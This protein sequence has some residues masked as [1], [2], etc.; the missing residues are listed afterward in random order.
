MKLRQAWRGDEVT[1]TKRDSFV[2]YLEDF[3]PPYVTWA[4]EKQR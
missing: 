4:L 2:Y 3:G 1:D